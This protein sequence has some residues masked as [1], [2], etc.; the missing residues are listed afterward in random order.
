MLSPEFSREIARIVLWTGLFSAPVS[1]RRRFVSCGTVIPQ[2]REERKKGPCVYP[3]ND[4]LV[5]P[6]QASCQNPA[7]MMLRRRKS[8]RPRNIKKGGVRPR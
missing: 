5:H 6:A 4:A 1:A 2:G 7:K 3:L 8:T